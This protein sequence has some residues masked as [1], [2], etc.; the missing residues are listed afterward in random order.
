MIC[1][2]LKPSQSF[3]VYRIQSEEKIL[4]ENSFLRKKGNGGLN[5]KPKESYGD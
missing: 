1:L 5:Q 2:T 3:F 4:Q